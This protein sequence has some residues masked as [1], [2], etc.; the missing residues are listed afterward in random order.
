MDWSVDV[1]GICIDYEVLNNNNEIIYK[2]GALF[3][4]GVASSFGWDRE[5]TLKQLIRKVL[6]TYH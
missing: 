2:S 6:P 5:E 4:P 1:H 3:L